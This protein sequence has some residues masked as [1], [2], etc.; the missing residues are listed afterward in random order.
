MIE[1]FGFTN[2]EL[3]QIE[4]FI[5]EQGGKTAKEILGGLIKNKRLNN[6]QKIVISYVVGNAV[7]YEAEKG[8]TRNAEIDISYIR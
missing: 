8:P 7:G 6:K 5:D 3:F 4:N 1:G 2:S